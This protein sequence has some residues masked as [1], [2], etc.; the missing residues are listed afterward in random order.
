MIVRFLRAC[1][2]CASVTA[3][4]AAQTAQPVLVLTNANLVD[5]ARGAFASGATIV[6]RNGLIAEIVSGPYTPPAGAQVI[7]VRGRFVLPGLIDAHTH[8]TSL[9]AAKRALE[10][11]VTTIRSASVPAFQDVALREAVRAGA[12]TGPDVVAT[13]VFVTPE[14]GETILSDSRL[15]A[16]AGGVTT[17]AALRQLVR[18][19][20][21]RGVNYIKTRGTERAGLPNTD[22]RR[23]TYT[24]TQLGWIVDEANRHQLPV[25]AHAH[26]DEG[27]WAA[28]RA[29]VRSIE[30][31]TFLSDSTLQLMKSRETFLVP[32]Y[33]TVV[34]LRD[35]G[36][37]YDDPVLR[38]RGQFMLPRLAEVVRRA[39]SLGVR[40]VAGADTDYGPESL[41]RVAGEVE[42]FVSLGMT[43]VEALR[44]ATT[45]AA[46]LLGIGDRTGRIA[47]GLQADLIVVDRNPLA[48]IRAL[49][50][51]LVVVSNGRVGLNRTPFS[52]PTM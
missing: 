10:S 33:I 35:S 44:T 49:A 14:L 28:V 29:G 9:A 43:P 16:L 41:S 19:N 4:A 51:V 5:G 32:T 6:V 11:G 38:L 20:A 50:D 30:H 39:H 42:S 47:V 45:N 21:D 34:D 40:I 23:Q 12:V 24:E 15:A 3:G 31:G 18:I 7:D 13:G 2:L 25:M 46:E 27:A 1:A 37:D 22:P 36:G 8:V 26:G 17:E 52:R 48:D